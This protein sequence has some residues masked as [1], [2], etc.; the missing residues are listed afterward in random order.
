MR[1]VGPPQQTP[2]GETRPRRTNTDKTH[3]NI[4]YY[5]VLASDSRDIPV[6]DIS[7]EPLVNP[8][9]LCAVFPHLDNHITHIEDYYLLLRNVRWDTFG[10]V[11]TMTPTYSQVI[12]KKCAH[13][14]A[15]TRESSKSPPHSVITPQEASLAPLST[16][17]VRV[18]LISASSSPW[19]FQ[20]LLSLVLWL[21]EP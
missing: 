15:F 19:H 10:L 16:V 5:P 8:V 12:H 9:E 21:C 20:P 13:K 17:H 2:L 11:R 3:E 7:P 4:S 18:T 6:A 1:Q 14:E